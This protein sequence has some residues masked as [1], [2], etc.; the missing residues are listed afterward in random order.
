MKKRR[1]LLGFLL[2]IFA[3][4]LSACDFLPTNLFGR[5]S[6]SQSSSRRIRSHNSDSSSY[7][8][9]HVHR[10]SADWSSNS[11]YHWHD[12][13]CGHD[14]KDSIGQHDFYIEVIEEANCQH[15]GQELYICNI[16]GYQKTVTTGIGD[17]HWSI[18]AQKDAT[19]T[20][21]GYVKKYCTI[22]NQDSQVTLSPLNHDFEI[23]ESE[24][25]APTCLESG[26]E[27]RHCLRCDFTET[28]PLEPIEHS[29]TSVELVEPTC[30]QAGYEK[31]TCKYCGRTET[32][33]LDKLPHSF[34]ESTRV[35][36]TCT[37]HGYVRYKCTVCH[38]VETVELPLASHV[39]SGNE[40]VVDS[41]N[42]MPYNTDYCLN[43][44]CTKIA[45]STSL[46]TINGTFKNSVASDY[47]YYKL[48]SNHNSLEI[49]F[50]YPN[51][52]YAKLYQHAVIENWDRGIYYDYTYRS[53][54]SYSSDGAQFN[55]EMECNNQIVDLSESGWTYYNDF[56]SGGVEIPELMNQGFS[57]A[58][59][60][61][62][63]DVALVSGIN[64]LKYTRTSTYTFYIDYFVLVIGT[65]T[66]HQH[67]LSS[68]YF[69]DANYHWQNCLD[70][71]CPMGSAAINKSAHNFIQETVYPGESCSDLAEVVYVC[72]TCG[73]RKVEYTRF[74]HNYDEANTSYVTNT[75]SRQLEIHHCE[76]CE[77]T[78]EGFDFTNGTFYAG[79]CSSLGR[80]EANTTIGWRFPV[81]QVGTISLYL[82]CKVQS[83]NYLQK[84]FD[85]ASYEIYING[86]FS[87][88]LVPYQTYEQLGISANNTVYVKFAS[89][90][91][92]EYDVATSEI[93]V[94]FNSYETNSYLRFSGQVRIE[95]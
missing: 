53:T 41:G 93:E 95:Y 49:S 6:S 66:S 79:S 44:G 34:E 59:D 1:V 45:L 21:A 48:A 43:C 36:S 58:A 86:T 88:L 22:C 74:D 80:L 39:W 50:E 37:E 17:H 35:E 61:L 63:G 25:R 69:S 84:Y 51:A 13:V 47:G 75:D 26:Y 32:I 15:G 77:R 10:F 19:C 94:R 55:F 2:P 60:C 16:C 5:N 18:Y 54:D 7:D 27:T 89:Y 78:V 30:S 20:E 71:D 46:A 3:L 24:S 11:Q 81:S 8:P 23:I 82:P 29:Y 42:G 87:E 62:I 38:Q 83:T 52:A 12:A 91:V 72:S 68:S 90:E 4:T 65:N 73:Y 85:P 57:P 56:F 64:T 76:T 70:P 40:S 14:E 92:T 33:T 67:T 31:I 9:T 28:V